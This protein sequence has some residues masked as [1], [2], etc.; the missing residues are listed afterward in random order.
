M[1]A[2]IDTQMLMKVITIKKDT[3]LMINLRMIQY[4]QHSHLERL[5]L[6]HI[7]AILLGKC[8]L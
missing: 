5:F 8:D 6:R 7:Y 2:E 4:S 1:F 3:Y